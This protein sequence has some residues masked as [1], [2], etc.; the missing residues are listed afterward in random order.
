[1]RSEDH[2]KPLMATVHLP[3]HEKHFPLCCLVKG[4]LGN[5]NSPE[6]FSLRQI[7]HIN[8]PT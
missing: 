2:D 7:G 4:T 8:H 1:M 3:L 5:E 6:S